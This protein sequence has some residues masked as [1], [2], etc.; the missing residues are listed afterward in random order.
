MAPNMTSSTTPDSPPPELAPPTVVAC[1]DA[2]AA[3][4]ILEEMRAAVGH[5]WRPLFQ[6]PALR[7]WHAAGEPGGR[8]WELE[9]ALAG[10][11]S[12]LSGTG[13]ASDLEH[14]A[15]RRARALGL[16]NAAVIDHWVNYAA[17]FE[18]AGTVVLPD[19][20]W[21]TDEYALA[22]ARQTFPGMPLRL[23]P[24]LYLQKQAGAVLR[25]GPACPG[26]VLFLAEP[27][28][29]S[30]PGLAQAGEIEALD[31]LVRHVD[32]LGLAAPLQLRLRPHPSDA[33]GKYDAWLA[34][35]PGLD[36]ALD[37]HADLAAA[38]AQAEWVAGCETAALVVALAAGR[39]AVS[40][41]PPEAPRCR[42]PH[43][44]LLHLRDLAPR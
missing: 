41:L 15:R 23:R 20:I 43:A 26:R 12:V 28:R 18:R 29:F 27:V 24:N 11:G 5:A 10:G 38:I 30:W 6:G 16:P 22:L 17:R 3:N 35:H 9:E 19:A 7:L 2:G 8:L 32:R 33:P 34:R 31:Y 21:V 42:L 39:R 14:E 37:A 36:A 40:V 44:D 25:G 13:W 4:I 1:H